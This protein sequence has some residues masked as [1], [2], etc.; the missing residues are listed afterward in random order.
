MGKIIGNDED[1]YQLNN[2]YSRIKYYTRK[3]FISNK[4]FFNLKHFRNLPIKLRKTQNSKL[5][6]NFMEEDCFE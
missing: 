5:L 3:T 6:N 2:K 1:D 4:Q